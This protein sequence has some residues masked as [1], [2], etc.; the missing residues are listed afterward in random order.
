MKKLIITLVLLVSTLVTAT[1]AAL[2]QSMAMQS[3]ASFKSNEDAGAPTV[4]RG[5]FAAIYPTVTNFPI[6][7]SGGTV[8]PLS[9]SAFGIRVQVTK[10]G[11]TWF[12]KL[13]FVTATQ[14]NA[15]MPYD[16]QGGEDPSGLVTVTIQKSD[17]TGGWINDRSKVYNIANQN[18]QTFVAYSGSTPLLNGDLW[19]CNNSTCTS[20][21][22]F[23]K[24]LLDGNPNPRSYNGN[25]V[26]VAI[27]V[28]GARSAPG[29]L[30]GHLN[31]T[32]RTD[33][34]LNS[35]QSTFEGV[36]QLNFRIPSDLSAGRHSFRTSLPSVDNDITSFAD[37]Q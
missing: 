4:A 18:P 27:Y 35:G 9:E 13:S 6:T 23:I 8:T 26:F 37:F 16:Q 14:I 2:A 34:K 10:S 30:R 15:I 3:G 31:G 11:Q 24:K 1:Y 20:G 22:T 32:L 36:E 21:A 7:G 19:G 12:A 25:P 29:D 33:L 5:S 17:G 28:S